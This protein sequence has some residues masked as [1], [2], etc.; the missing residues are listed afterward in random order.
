VH[1][2]CL[3]V[4]STTRFDLKILGFG[5][6]LC[7]LSFSLVALSAQ[8]STPEGTLTANPAY[9]QN[10]A[11][12]HGKNA[13]GRHFGGPSLASE[14]ETLASADDLRNI[15]ANGKHRMPKYAGKLTPEEIDAL[16]QQIKNL[17]KK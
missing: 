6:V 3:L 15:I 2:N 5:L 4:N 9:Q 13:E 11:K 8:T 10:C 12:C 17:N 1:Q 16:V 14:K 7:C